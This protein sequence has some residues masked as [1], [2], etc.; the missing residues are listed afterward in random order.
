MTLIGR[1]SDGLLLCASVEAMEESQELYDYNRQAKEILKS[2]SKNSPSRLH[3]ETGP[4]YFVYSI[5]GELCYLTLCDKSY[6]RK[7]AFNFLD[8][9]ARE[10]PLSHTPNDVLNAKRPYQFIEFESFIQKT[11]KLYTDSRTQRNLAKVSEEL[12][13]V[14]S[15]MTKNI[16]E[17]LGRGEKI[18]S[19]NKKLDDLLSQSKQ[20]SELGKMLN[21]KDFWKT[22]KPLLIVGLI[23]FFCF[24]IYFTFY[25]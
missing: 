24:C 1:V 12:Q 16:V 13:S 17:I 8:E 18:T 9:I 2:L 11:K 25:V 20:Y 4:F 14:H 23:L 10:F 5:S 19:V 6:P 3:I 21:K 22:Y 15:I 7:L